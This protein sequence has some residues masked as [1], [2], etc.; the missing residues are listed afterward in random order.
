MR[1]R[2]WRR[3]DPALSC[4]EVVELTTDYLEGRLAELERLVEQHLDDCDGCSEYIAQM[5]ATIDLLREVGESGASDE[6]VAAV[7]A[8]LER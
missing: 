3:D 1:L 2:F 7:L 5:R 4:R 6:E 8:T